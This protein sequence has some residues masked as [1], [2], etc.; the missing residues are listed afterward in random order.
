MAGPQVRW[1][2]ES[3]RLGVLVRGRTSATVTQLSTSYS[4]EVRL[5]MHLLDQKKALKCERISWLVHGKPRIAAS[6]AKEV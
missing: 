4:N 3:V 1:T 6:E 2:K 5:Q